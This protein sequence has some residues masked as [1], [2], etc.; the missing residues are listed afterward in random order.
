MWPVFAMPEKLLPAL[1]F[2]GIEPAASAMRK[3]TFKGADFVDCP[4]EIKKL[5]T[6]NLIY[7]AIA[8]VVVHRDLPFRPFKALWAKHRAKS[9]P[10]AEQTDEPQEKEA[11]AATPESNDTTQAA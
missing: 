6:L 10:Q 8:L 9:A 4:R 3:I 2:L 7:L 5:L 11:V 1:D